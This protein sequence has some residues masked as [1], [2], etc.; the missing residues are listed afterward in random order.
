MDTDVL[1][2]YFLRNGWQIV[3]DPELAD[4][5]MLVT[6]SFVKLTEQ[7]AVD[8][9]TRFQEYDTDLLVTGCLPGINKKRLDSIFPGESIAIKN[10]DDIDLLFPEHTVRY[11]DIQDTNFLYEQQKQLSGVSVTAAQIGKYILAYARFSPNFYRN[12]WRN[13]ASIAKSKMGTNRKAYYLRVGWGC[14]EPHCTFCV[15]WL[16]VGGKFISKP[17]ETIEREVQMGIEQ[18]YT[19]FAVLSDNPGGYG[20]DTGT[21]IVELLDRI[22]HVSD[23][24]RIST[25]D[26]FHPYFIIKNLPALKSVV[27]QRR[28]DFIMTPMQAGSDRILE[29]MN[30]RYT[31]G[32]MHDALAALCEQDPHLRFNSQ[33]IVGF[34]TET[35]EDFQMSLRRVKEM[36]FLN[37]TVFPYCKNDVTPSSGLEPQVPDEVIHDRVQRTRD[38]L[39][40]NGIFSFQLGVDI[41]RRFFQKEQPRNQ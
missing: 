29:L 20:L 12:A 26:G 7:I 4:R 23:D 18:G 2:E 34:P 15:E 9:I 28:I 30:R 38:F 16:A 8:E 31:G 21:N 6:C 17:L 36:D 41:Q 1:K 24:I 40:R 27:A 22:L 37:V 14:G 39:G 11:K 33:M 5:N 10:I 35:E 3:D 25:I 32:Q 19:R 13:A